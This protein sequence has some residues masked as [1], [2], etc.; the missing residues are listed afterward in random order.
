MISLNRKLPDVRDAWCKKEKYS[1]NLPAASIIICFHNE[2][3]STL[4]RTVHSVLNRSP[5]ELIKEIILFDDYSTMKH[6]KSNLEDYI[7]KLPK[8]ILVRSARREGL[9]RARM[10]AIEYSTGSVLVFLDSHCEC[11]KG[12]LEP[13]LDRI[14]KDPKTVVSPAVDLIN[15]NTFQYTPQRANDLRIGGF[16]W[17]L[18]FIW[19][20][21]PYKTQL[22]RLNPAAPIKTP[23]ISGGLFAID[24]EFFEKIGLYDEELDTWG[25]ENLELSFKTWMCGGNLEIVPCSHVGHVFR[26]KIPYDKEDASLNRNLLRVAEVWMDDYKKYFLERIGNP[27]IYLKDVSDRKKLRDD[28][29]CKSFQWYL[30][31]V[32]PQLE[33]PDKYVASGIIY[34]IGQRLCL[35]MSIFDGDIKFLVQALPCH[36]G[37]GN[38][39]WI[40]TKQGHIKRD[41]YC[42]EYTG[43]VLQIFLCDG[44]FDHQR[45]LYNNMTRHIKHVKTKKCLQI[46]KYANQNSD[47]DFTITVDQCA[48]PSLP[49]Q[50]WAMQRFISERLDPILYTH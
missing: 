12:W 7:R 46:S 18:K 38:Q 39:Y 48:S 25:G 47:F 40:Y 41:E 1:Q 19:M 34:N 8:V 4:I 49:L 3:W 31:N 35:D 20:L 32:Y 9:I 22:K 24:K 44:S 6:L 50:Q 15:D 17:N 14:A 2:A 28:L 10:K 21:M 33:I 42:L 45:W 23:T 27:R 16:N 26:K 29:N 43:K 37:G 30:N 11:I 5:R 36:Y 13:L